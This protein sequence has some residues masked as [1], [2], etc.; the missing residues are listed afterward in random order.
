MG[1]SFAYLVP[2]IQATANPKTKI[3]VST[4]TIAL[5]EQLLSKD[6]PFLR[7]VMPQEFSAVLVKGRSNYI[8]LRRLNLAVQR[9]E[10]LFQQP[11]EFD[12][13]ATI[14]MWS[15]RTADGSR[16]DLDFRPMPSVWE[17]VQSE[18]GNCLGRECPNHQECFFYK[19]RRRMRSA[20]VLVVNHALFVA[21]L[22]LR[23]EG[24]G[25][26][27]DYQVAMIDEAHTLEAVAGEHLGLQLTNLGVD[28]TL[29]RLYN[30]RS[31]KGL[32]AITQ[33]RRRRST[34]CGRPGRRPTTSS[35][36]WPTGT[37]ASP[38]ASTAGSGSRSA[39]PS[40]CARSCARLAT[41]ID[42]GAQHIEQPEDRVE[43]DRRRG[44]VPD[45]GRP[46]RELDAASD[47][48]SASTG[49]SWRTGPDGGS[50]WPPRP[51]RRP[52]PAN[53]LFTEVPTCVLTSATLCV[54]S[55]PRFD[56][57]KRGS[58]LTAAETLALGSPFDYAHQVTVHL[59]KN[60]P[61]P[62]DQPARSK[63]RPSARSPITSSGPRARR[64]SCS[65]PT[66]CSRP[67]RAP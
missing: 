60:L 12:Q 42:L 20:N 25:L 59:P 51:R 34:R 35:T 7:S 26:L 41:A 27:P 46:D 24:F 36:D 65:P 58:A 44:T 22:A 56:F 47:S 18:D 23:G 15:G 40:T 67:P 57:I 62:S 52:E 30:E 54:G 10:G 33:A 14:R 48:E 13:L 39:G 3:V 5:Q 31:H 17:A 21:D 66:R 29:A 50:G 49:S 19:A 37:S 64:S 4:H 45:D 61:D 6:I 43:F 11:E 8:S 63:R 9:Q 55:P 32:L 1:K 38:R 28:Y 2:A 16:S 53:L